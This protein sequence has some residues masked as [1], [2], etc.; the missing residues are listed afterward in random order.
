MSFRLMNQIACFAIVTA[1][2]CQEGG[3]MTDCSNDQKIHD[4]ETALKELRS[5]VQGM[6][7]YFD[8]AEALHKE[9][10]AAAHMER[11]ELRD[12]IRELR[13]M[14]PEKRVA[15]VIDLTDEELE[16]ARTGKVI[17]AMKSVRSR[18]H[19]DLKTAK[20]L[21]DRIKPREA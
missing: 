19:V 17:D 4:L 5:E 1:G 12:V 6:R 2:L 16:L 7:S 21:V 10:L 13:S 15:D 3:V 18:L 14:P 8:K 9:Q 20:A 11:N